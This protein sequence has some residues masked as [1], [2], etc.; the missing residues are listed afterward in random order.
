MAD[1]VDLVL[2]GLGSALEGMGET[3]RDLG[4]T[5]GA[6]RG[7]LAHASH[8]SGELM[9]GAARLRVQIFRLAEILESPGMRRLIA[10]GV[11]LFLAGS[12]LLR[13]ILPSPSGKK[14][15]FP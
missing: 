2:D 10:A 4:E 15:L 7:Q 5:V 8:F 12:N 1:K 11:I 6:A 3:M 9:D 13:A 14:R